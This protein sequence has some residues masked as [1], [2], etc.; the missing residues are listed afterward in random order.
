MEYPDDSQGG[1]GAIQQGELGTAR[2]IAFVSHGHRLTHAGGGGGSGAGVCG[3]PGIGA[4]GSSGMLPGLGGTLSGFG[5]GV[6]FA[7][8]GLGTGV[9]S[10]G[11]IRVIVP[12][13]R[14]TLRSFFLGHQ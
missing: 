14:I 13:I 7:G 5:G 4:I 12:F 3:G 6:G 8:A 9:G 2:E 10:T 11:I 1:F